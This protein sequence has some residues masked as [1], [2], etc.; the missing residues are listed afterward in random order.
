MDEDGEIIAE[1]EY[2]IDTYIEFAGIVLIN[3]NVLI[4]DTYKS[5]RIAFFSKDG[6]LLA[7]PEGIFDEVCMTTTH[8]TENHNSLYFMC[9]FFMDNLP[10]YNYLEILSD[11]SRKELY[12]DAQVA[13]IGRIY[14]IDASDV[15]SFVARTIFYETLLNEDRYG[16]STGHGA[17]LICIGAENIYRDA[18]INGLQPVCYVSKCK[19]GCDDYYSLKCI[20][21]EVVDPVLFSNNRYISCSGRGDVLDCYGELNS[22]TLPEFKQPPVVSTQYSP[23]TG[24]FWQGGMWT[25]SL[26]TIRKGAVANYAP[27]GI[28][29]IPFGF[30]E[31]IVGGGIMHALFKNDDLGT[32]YG[33]STYVGIIGSFNTVLIGYPKLNP[34]LEAE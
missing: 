29:L 34:K 6:D 15:S 2:P 11:N 23:N 25:L 8:Y 24:N 9:D 16:I 7:G 3:N 18:E 19:C 13:K 31:P 32:A 28:T 1:R 27:P 17:E 20:V 26:D 5:G 22:L 12:I 10:S 33:R 21:G 4:F 30:G 14:G